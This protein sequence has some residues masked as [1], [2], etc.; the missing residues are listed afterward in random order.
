MNTRRTDTARDHDDRD[1]IEGTRPPPSQGGTAGGNLAR[2]VA[3]QGEEEHVADPDRRER[4]TKKDDIG[5]DAAYPS[6]RPRD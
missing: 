2:D 4:A 6:R 3:T 5:N 1:I